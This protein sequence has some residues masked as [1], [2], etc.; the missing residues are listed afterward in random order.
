MRP[1]ARIP[2]LVIAGISLVKFP[3]GTVVGGLTLWY[4]LREEGAERR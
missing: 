4:L 3:V 2:T 1:W